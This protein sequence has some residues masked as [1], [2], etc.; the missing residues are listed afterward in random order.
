MNDE[1]AGWTKG[2]ELEVVTME[3]VT[4]PTGASEA[5]MAP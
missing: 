3:T 4:A 2:A 1:K 5:G